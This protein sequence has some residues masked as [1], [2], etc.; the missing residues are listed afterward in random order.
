MSEGVVD[1]LE[2]LWWNDVVE[3]STS[4]T[5]WDIQQ[6]FPNTMLKVHLDFFFNCKMWE[7]G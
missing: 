4:E 2:E 6:R 3:S 5:N 1:S 7:D